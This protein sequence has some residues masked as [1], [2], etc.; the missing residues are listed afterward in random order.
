MANLSCVWDTMLTQGMVVRAVQK[1]A[2]E[3]AEEAEEAVGMM[4]GMTL[5]GKLE[6][7]RIYVRCELRQKHVR[8]LALV[9][10]PGYVLASPSSGAGANIRQDGVQMRLD[11]TLLSLTFVQLWFEPGEVGKQERDQ[12]VGRGVQES[13]GKEVGAG[14]SPGL[15]AFQ[16]FYSLMLTRCP[17]LPTIR[18]SEECSWR[19]TNKVTRRVFTMCTY[20]AAA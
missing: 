4:L 9:D 11:G 12:G 6:E 10:M 15:R 3:G 14:R 5:L 8:R 19:L 18:A 20:K 16:R 2:T 1:A 7:P 13:V 17:G